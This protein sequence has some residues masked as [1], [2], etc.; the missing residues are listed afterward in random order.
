MKEEQRARRG[1]EVE[2]VVEV[3]SEVVSGDVVT[4]KPTT[5]GDGL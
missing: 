4:E 3:A 1:V 2:A 5:R